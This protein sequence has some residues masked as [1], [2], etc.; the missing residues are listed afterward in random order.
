MFRGE[1]D[2]RLRASS[3]RSIIMTS[4]SRPRKPLNVKGGSSALFFS[5]ASAFPPRLKRH[6]RVL[7]TRSITGA[8]RKV[9]DA[10]ATSVCSSSVSVTGSSPVVKLLKLSS[11]RLGVSDRNSSSS[12][13]G[14][15]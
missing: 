3:W 2:W 9:G 6:L 8:C 7:G 15:R 10:M 4:G 12:L 14:A 13:G 5:L 1:F 11:V